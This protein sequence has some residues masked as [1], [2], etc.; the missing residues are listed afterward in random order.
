MLTVATAKNI[1]GIIEPV[2]LPDLG[3]DFAYAKI[4]TGAYSG[5]IHCESITPM[6]S[7][8]GRKYLQVVPVDATHRPVDIY[9]YRVTYTTS[10]TGH[11]IRRYVIDTFILINGKG[12]TISIGLAT[13]DNMKVKVLIGR[14][15]IRKNKLLVDVTKNQDLDD[16]GGKKL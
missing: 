13:R 15:F 5:A 6:R 10:S 2:K 14:R 9:R 4:D 16:D 3:V 8:L 7:E 1:L 11:R 12:Y